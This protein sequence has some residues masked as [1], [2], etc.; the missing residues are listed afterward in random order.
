[1]VALIKGSKHLH[2]KEYLFEG[3]VIFC[4]KNEMLLNNYIDYKELK[5]LLKTKEDK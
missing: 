5:T 3:L 1:M 4:L 2:L